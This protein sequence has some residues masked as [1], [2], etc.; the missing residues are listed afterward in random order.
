MTINN[1][2]L[3]ARDEQ[4]YVVYPYYPVLQFK[5]SNQLYFS[6][7]SFPH[8]SDRNFLLKV[9]QSEYELLLQAFF[10]FSQY[11]FKPKNKLQFSFVLSYQT[12]YCFRNAM[13]LSNSSNS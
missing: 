7:G 3:V 12:K 4:L 1:S 8:I 6:F 13:Y 2:H 9:K 10:S 5:P 11:K